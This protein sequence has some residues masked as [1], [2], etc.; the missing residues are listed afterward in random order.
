MIAITKLFIGKDGKRIVAVECV[1]RQ[2]GMTETMLNRPCSTFSSLVSSGQVENA[3]WTKDGAVF[4]G[5]IP[6]F[7]YAS[8]CSKI[9]QALKDN[10]NFII[11]SF[12]QLE[13]ALSEMKNQIDGASFYFTKYDN[14]YWISTQKA[15]MVSQIASV[16]RRNPDFALKVNHG[17]RMMIDSVDSSGKI[18]TVNVSKETEAAIKKFFKQ[19]GATKRQAMQMYQAGQLYQG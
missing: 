8:M 12:N 6:R 5:N 13:Q 4:T 14:R 10:G 11:I 2:N 18:S 17:V 9:K 7:K 1:D 16:C 19:S 15:V 3:H